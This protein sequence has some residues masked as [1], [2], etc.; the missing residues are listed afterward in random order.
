MLGIEQQMA[1]DDAKTAIRRTV[2]SLET[3]FGMGRAYSVNRQ[4]LGAMVEL[5]RL[6]REG[7]V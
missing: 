2:A 4:L 7:A 1:I 6:E 5:D 3:K